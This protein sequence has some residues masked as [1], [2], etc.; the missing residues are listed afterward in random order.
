MSGRTESGVAGS[1]GERR[2]APIAAQRDGKANGPSANRAGALGRAGVEDQE[3]GAVIRRG[4]AVPDP[5][6]RPAREVDGGGGHVDGG[7]APPAQSGRAA[8]PRVERA[9]KR[10]R[11]TAA[12]RLDRAHHPD[13]A[14]Q[15]D[16]APIAAQNRNRGRKLANGIADRRVC[17]QASLRVHLPFHREPYVALAFDFTSGFHDTANA[18]ATSIATGALKPW[19]PSWST[20]WR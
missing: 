18:M 13:V 7:P 6:T 14:R 20:A 11:V 12:V 8:D 9:P 2:A 15:L 3:T 5:P 4:V 16:G 19:P 10:A 1:G 17:G